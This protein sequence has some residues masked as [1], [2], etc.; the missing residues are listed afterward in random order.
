MKDFFSIHQKR[1]RPRKANTA[2][3]VVPTQITRKKLKTVVAAAAVAAAVG[4]KLKTIAAAVVTAVVATAK[5]I[6]WS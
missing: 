3:D 2:S 4:A 1:G 6:N 5:R